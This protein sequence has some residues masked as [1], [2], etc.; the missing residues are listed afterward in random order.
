MHH[1]PSSDLH[2]HN[3]DRY[4]NVKEKKVELVMIDRFLRPQNLYIEEME[5]S[6][7]V[8]KCT[9]NKKKSIKNKADIFPRRAA[10]A[11]SLAKASE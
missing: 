5:S 3:Q 9:S 11:S 2:H 4:K 10:F 7:A 1:L 8:V 6:S